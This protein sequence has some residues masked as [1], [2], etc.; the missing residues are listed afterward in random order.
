MCNENNIYLHSDEVYKP[1]FHSLPEETIKPPSACE[2]YNKAIVTGSISKAFSLAG[3]RLG[4]I[5]TKDHS[6]LRS[7]SSRRDYNTISVSMIDDLITQYALQNTEPI[8]KCN[9]NLVLDNLQILSQFVHENSDL[10]DFIA[11]LQ[12]GTVCL[13]GLKIIKDGYKFATYLADKYKV[14]CI[15]GETLG[16]SGTLRIGYADSKHDLLKGLPL[17]KKAVLDWTNQQ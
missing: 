14:L 12:G 3:I 2:L 5:I 1:I 9:Y 10:F 16:I 6:V 7:A 13:L 4:W 8:I 17:L 15:P 11:K